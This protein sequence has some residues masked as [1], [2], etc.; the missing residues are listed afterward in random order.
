MCQCYK[1][2]VYK[3]I[4]LIRLAASRVRADRFRK[5]YQTSPASRKELYKR[6]TAEQIKQIKNYEKTYNM[7]CKMKEK[8]NEVIMYI[9]HSDVKFD[10]DIEKLKEYIN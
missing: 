10:V 3:I 9:E 6:L 8:L 2:K 5:R 4:I 7:L 1:Y